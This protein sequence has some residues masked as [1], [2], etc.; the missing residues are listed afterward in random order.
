MNIEETKQVLM[1]RRSIRRYNPNPLASEEINTIAEYIPSINTLEQSNQLRVLIKNPS[2]NK[3]L[4]SF[5]PTFG[6]MI[7]P[8]HFLVPYIFGEESSL[9]DLGFRMQQVVIQMWRNGIGSCFIGCLS[10]EEKIK[11]YFD[12]PDTCRIAAILVF[13]KPKY[14]FEGFLINRLFRKIYGGDRRKALS[15][16]FFLNGFDNPCLPPNCINTIIELARYSPSA[17]NSQPWRF[18]LKGEDL[19]LFIL[20]PKDMVKNTRLNYA[21]HDAGICMANITYALAAYRKSQRWKFIKQMDKTNEI[22]EEM[23]LIA[24]HSLKGLLDND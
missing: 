5:L 11:R 2:Q 8:P 14:G 13:G 9:I 15:E 6:K 19:Y 7:S 16:I 12:L 20:K 24:K 4:I 3:E 1:S 18:L 21:F 22:P 23:V 10:N 17:I